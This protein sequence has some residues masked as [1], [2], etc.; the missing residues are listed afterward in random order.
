VEATSLKPILPDRYSYPRANKAGFEERHGEI[1][2]L[3][4]HCIQKIGFGSAKDGLLAAVAA[5][6][7]EV[8]TVPAVSR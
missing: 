2:D 3:L 4:P 7:V 5:V 6:I 1:H 8:T